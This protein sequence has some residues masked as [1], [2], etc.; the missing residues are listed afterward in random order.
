MGGA[1]TAELRKLFTTRLW[2]G[3]AIAMFIA[4]AGLAGLF[5]AIAGSDFGG[6][7]D[8]GRPPTRTPLRRATNVYTGGPAAS[9]TC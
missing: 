7:G 3:M 8:G 9:A 5:A 1:I 6:G 2:W 4:G